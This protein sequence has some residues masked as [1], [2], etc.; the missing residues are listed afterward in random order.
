MFDCFTAMINSIE[1]WIPLYF[2]HLF[3]DDNQH[4]YFQTSCFVCRAHVSET[5]LE[6]NK[7]RT[8]LFLKKKLEIQKK[9]DSPWS[10][11]SPL[12]LS[13]YVSLSPFPAGKKD[14]HGES[15]AGA[16]RGGRWCAVR[17][18]G[19]RLWLLGSS[20]EEV[21]QFHWGAATC[22]QTLEQVR[23]FKRF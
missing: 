11:W 2:L 22:C 1:T 6:E 9:Q 20:K 12:A 8:S 10:A 16:D 7:K 14:H 18:P 4:W 23:I 3:K 17:R 13:V 5:P 19:G 15:L 21:S